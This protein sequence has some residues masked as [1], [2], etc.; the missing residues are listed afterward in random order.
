MKKFIALFLALTLIFSVG[1]MVSCSDDEKDETQLKIGFLNGPTGIG[2]AEL[3][4][5]NGGLD[6]NEKY[7][8][9]KFDDTNEAAAAL[10]AGK[11]DIVCLPTNEA[12]KIYNSASVDVDVQVLAINCL[13]SLYVVAKNDISINSFADLEGKTVY[14]C[15][16]GTPAIILNKLIS[17]YGLNITVK[18]EIGEGDSATVI[19]KPQDLPAVIVAGKAD[20]VIAPEPIVTNALLKTDNYSV[21]VDLGDVWDAKYSTPLAMGCVVARKDFVDAHKT[22]IDSFLADYENSIKF[23]SKEENLNTAS[24]Y[25]VDTGIMAAVP[26]AKKAISNLGDSIAYLDGQE[27]KE[28]LEN[29]YKAFG[30]NV[31]GGKIPD[32]DFYYNV[33]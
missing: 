2:M 7:D 1:A 21:K 24:Q 27:M 16:N 26:A 9:T 6:G 32:E 20:I 31:I 5:N 8:F 15:K 12:A 4:V 19:A 17:E 18:T 11:L 23:M 10:Q 33:K 28:S 25:A 14:T 22:V 13:N 30:M 29:V 3:I